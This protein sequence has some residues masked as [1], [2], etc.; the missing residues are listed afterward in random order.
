MVLA[1][2]E[3]AAEM[4]GTISLL[5]DIA[6]RAAFVSALA[7]WRRPAPVQKLQ[8]Q[9]LVPRAAEHASANSCRS[10]ARRPSQVQ[11][12]KCVR[13]IPPALV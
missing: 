11:I 4:I 13:L 7:F 9:N 12:L 5:A 6:D 3:K 2:T 1:L 8:V 10:P